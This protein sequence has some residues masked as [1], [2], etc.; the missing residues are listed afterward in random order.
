MNA[1]LIAIGTELLL[2]HTINTNAVYLSRR[3]AGVGIP[4]F[5]HTVVG[6]NPER[7]L[8]VLR[9]ARRRASLLILTGGLGPTVDDVTVATVARFLH[10]P[11][12]HHPAIARTIRQRFTRR[13]LRMP[14]GNLRQAWLPHGA[15]PLPNALG[16]APGFIR[17]D[18]D[19][20]I[21]AFPGVPAEMEAMVERSFMPWLRARGLGRG[22]VRSRTLKI[23][24]QPESAIDA[25]VRPWLRLPPP[26]TVGIYAQPGEVHLRIMA[27]APTER[28]AQQAIARVERALRAR[29]GF[30]CF[31]ADEETL[32]SVAGALCVRRRLTLAVAE[33]CTGGLVT[34]RLT[35]IPGSSA[36][37][38]AGIMAYSN[39]VK[40]RVLGVS[41]AL[42]QR[43]GA[44]SAPVARAL[45]RGAQRITASD[46]GV[47][48]TGIAG[49]TGGTRAKPVGLV[50]IGLA[51][52]ARTIVRRGHFLGTRRSIKRQASQ[53]ALDL[54][55]RH[56][57]CLARSR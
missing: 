14:A 56:L 31:G 30:D 29:L 46:I 55:R 39:D 26:V 32:E 36:Y 45:A 5:H 43:H 25:R 53:A 3:L 24:G 49:P 37:V 9:I 48:L 41:H 52:G 44:V 50:F 12:V 54:L 13:H 20:W 57:L 15:R 18:G 51:Y 34:D 17:Q 40:E 11:L 2:G 7:L 23:A 19:G 6:D 38:R 4:C 1:E 35:N 27:S 21:V 10:G 33:S 22:V 28:A 16:T 8:E 42:V 47:S